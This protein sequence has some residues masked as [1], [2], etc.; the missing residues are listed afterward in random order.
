M[1]NIVQL[2]GYNSNRL[3]SPAIWSD[4]PIEAIKGG[5][6]DG[7]YFFDD[8]DSLSAQT[9]GTESGPYYFFGDTGGTCTKTADSDHG[10]AVLTFD[11]TDEDGIGL[12]YGNAAGFGRFTS[13]D[14]LWMEARYAP[15]QVGDAMYSAFLG[16]AEINVV[17]TGD[18]IMVDATGVLDASEDFVGWRTILGNGDYFEPIYQEGSAT[19]KAVGADGTANATGSGYGGVVAASTF[20]KWGMKW[21]GSKQLLEYFYNGT[22][23]AYITVTSSLSFPDVNHM[24]M[25]IAAKAHTAVAH[26]VSLDWWAVGAISEG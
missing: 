20:Q 13:I 23:V 10:I 19:L 26:T 14:K 21:N 11:G 9:L 3:H 12:C 16:M 7:H 24:A 17:P 25:M 4:C 2:K 1:T 6:T 22:R 18:A 5:R 8:F 15:G